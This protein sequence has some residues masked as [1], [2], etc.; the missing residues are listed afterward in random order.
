[1]GFNVHIQSK[2]LQHTFVMCTN[3]DLGQS[4]PRQKKGG[5]LGWEKSMLSH[6]DIPT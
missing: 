6:H 1:M 2:L 4:F 5:G 3:P